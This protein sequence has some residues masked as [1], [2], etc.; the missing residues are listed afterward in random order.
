MVTGTI[1]ASR[2]AL[3]RQKLCDRGFIQVKKQT[4]VY[5]PQLPASHPAIF[6]CCSSLISRD[7]PPI[8]PTVGQ[9]YPYTQQYAY[10]YRFV[11]HGK[12]RIEKIAEFR[13]TPKE[14]VFAFA[15]GDLQADG[16][17]DVYAISNN[18]DMLRVLATIISILNRFLTDHSKA[19]V[20]FTG[21]TDNRSRIYQRIL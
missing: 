19:T 12:E 18:G 10:Q 6:I 2:P 16:T 11:S 8:P 20:F 13:S 9:P 4:E 7:S 3:L 1:S 14:N 5:A 15:F 21:S 17:V